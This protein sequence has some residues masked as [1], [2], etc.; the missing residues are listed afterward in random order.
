[1]CQPIKVLGKLGQLLD[2]DV[3]PRVGN[4]GIV[5][6]GD[7]VSSDFFRA[8]EK[9]HERQ[10]T[11]R[12]ETRPWARPP[13]GQRQAGGFGASCPTPPPV[14]SDLRTLYRN[15]L[16]AVLQAYPETQVWEQE[17]GLW[18]RTESLLLPK[19]NRKA[20]FLTGVPFSRERL[21]RGW[22]FW[23]GIPM[24]QPQWI[25]PRHT[26]M[27]DGSI[28]AFDPNDGTWAVGGALVSLLD[29]Y[30]VWAL[31]HLHLQILGY[32]PGRQVA[33]YVT[34]R[35]AE[36]KPFELCGCGGD[37]LYEECCRAADLKADRLSEAMRFHA[38]GGFHRCPPQAI[39]KFVREDG[40]P[41][42]IND[43]LPLFRFGQLAIGRR[44]SGSSFLQ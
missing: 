25:G 4:N 10:G 40:L 3:F 29:L 17:D 36:L 2:A 21:P 12:P 42:D 8:K 7:V 43:V 14:C 23:M 33:N 5:I 16:T 13:G 19:L 15:E 6:P 37:K 28:C 26:N 34:E 27:P 44:Q 39:L 35:L 31:R 32:W 18:F 38:L 30:T 24:K 1:M 22:G 11:R 9:S 41:P 20:V